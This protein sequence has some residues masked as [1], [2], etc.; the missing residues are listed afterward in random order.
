[1]YSRRKFPYTKTKADEKIRRLSKST[2]VVL[3]VE[4]EQDPTPRLA[5]EANDTNNGDEGAEGVD[6][7]TAVSIEEETARR[8]AKVSLQGPH[9]WSTRYYGSSGEWQAPAWKV[10]GLGF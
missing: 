5:E 6:A 1:M 4:G 9:V 7:A 10:Q 8:K 3:R 2:Q